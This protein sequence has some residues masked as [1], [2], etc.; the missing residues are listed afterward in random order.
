MIVAVSA[1]VLM[2]CRSDK[3]EVITS[4]Q[5][6]KA[7]DIRKSGKDSTGKYGAAGAGKRAGKKS[8]GRICEKYR[9][10]DWGRV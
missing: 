5:L 4:S 2:S 3:K 8:S 1:V 9:G 6:E 10:T 7:I